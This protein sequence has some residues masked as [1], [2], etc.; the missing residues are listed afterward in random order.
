MQ[1]DGWPEESEWREQDLFSE[2]EMENAKR[3]IIN[4][5]KDLRAQPE[6]SVWPGEAVA[7]V[8][9]DLQAAWRSHH[10]P[11]FLTAMELLMW[12][13]LTQGLDKVG[14]SLNI[15]CPPLK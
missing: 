14:A 3:T 15:N 10:M 5:T 4:W 13:L 7:Q 12:V 1:S 8:L 2:N 6:Q 11:N 9:E